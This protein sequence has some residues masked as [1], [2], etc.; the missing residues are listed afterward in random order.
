MTHAPSS[1]EGRLIALGLT[2]PEPLPAFGEYV[3]A[4]RSGDRL[5]VG[6]HFG[7]GPDGS[8]LTGRVGSDV[9]PEAAAVAAAKSEW[10]WSRESGRKRER[11]R[12]SSVCQAVIVGLMHRMTH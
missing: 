10:S 8:I 9:D 5:W 3:P 7:T 12:I 2:L 11:P 4:V 6:G 1:A